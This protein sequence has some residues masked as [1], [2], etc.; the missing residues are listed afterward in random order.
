MKYNKKPKHIFGMFRLLYTKDIFDNYI[1]KH[2]VRDQ[3][4]RLCVPYK[5]NLEFLGEDLKLAT[6]ILPISENL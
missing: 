4:R 5:E 3:N 1:N 6:L 2:I